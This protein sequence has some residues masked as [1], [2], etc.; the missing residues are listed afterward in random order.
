MKANNIIP[1]EINNDIVNRFRKL[2]CIVT[3]HAAPENTES[4]EQALEYYWRE[5]FCKQREYHFYYLVTPQGNVYLLNPCLLHRYFDNGD[6]SYQKLEKSLF[7][8]EY[9]L[10]KSLPYKYTGLVNVLNFCDVYPA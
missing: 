4:D 9:Q 7:V 10:M 8:G 6:I 1:T 5:I 3:N 2:D